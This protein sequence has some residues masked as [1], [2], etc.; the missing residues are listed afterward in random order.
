M[1]VLGKF[2][3][4]GTESSEGQKI[5]VELEKLQIERTKIRTTSVTSASTETPTETSINLPVMI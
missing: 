4:V 3:T 2:E 1:S 5:L